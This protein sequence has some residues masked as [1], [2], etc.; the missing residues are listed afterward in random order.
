MH[1]TAKIFLIS[2][3]TQTADK[4]LELINNTDGLKDQLLMCFYEFLYGRGNDCSGLV[5]KLLKFSLICVP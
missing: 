5:Y 2:I 1:L 3:S 4:V